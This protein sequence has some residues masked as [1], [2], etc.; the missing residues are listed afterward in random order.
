MATNPPKFR[1]IRTVG[2]TIKRFSDRVAPSTT[3]T[4]MVAV[5]EFTPPVLTSELVVNIL[6]HI[7]DGSTFEMAAAR[8][9]LTNEN[10]QQW[11][12]VGMSIL[13][14]GKRTL[15]DYEKLC[16]QL[17][18]EMRRTRA[19]V[20]AIAVSRIL[21][22]ADWKAQAWYLEK[23]GG[24]VF[25]NRIKVITEETGQQSGS[26]DL[27]RLSADQRKQLLELL[28]Q[29]AGEPRLISATVESKE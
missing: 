13:T 23:V 22:H 3:H 17:T 5:H 21:L 26:L 15:N 10:L 24:N 25:E 11:V 14:G 16:M 19:E 8:A 20:L 27:A 2:Q 4:G 29:A 28:D 1:P 18:L 12:A 7:R 6:G 9:N